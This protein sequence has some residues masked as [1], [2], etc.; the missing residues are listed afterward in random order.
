VSSLVLVPLTPAFFIPESLAVAS[1]LL[2]FL[3]FTFRIA[4]NVASLVLSFIRP[5][6][7]VLTFLISPLILISL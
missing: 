2:L 1:L 4:T 3:T 5:I 7:L 6:K